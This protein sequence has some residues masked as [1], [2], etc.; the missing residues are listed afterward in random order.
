MFNFITRLKIVRTKFRD[1]N[2]D[3]PYTTPYSD[4]LEKNY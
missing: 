4:G 3:F 1:L 2:S